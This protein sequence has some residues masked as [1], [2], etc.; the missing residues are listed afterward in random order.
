MYK[1]LKLGEKMI[2]STDDMDDENPIKRKA[3]SRGLLNM[4][5]RL[6][7]HESQKVYEVV[8]KLLETHFEKNL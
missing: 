7:N 1:F 5:I 2:G 4:L 3:L 6:Q 8:S